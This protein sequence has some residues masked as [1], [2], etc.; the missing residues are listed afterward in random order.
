[1]E[2]VSYSETPVLNPASLKGKRVGMVMFSSY[3]ADPRPR[4]AVEALLKEGM[5]VDLVCLQDEHA[6]KRETHGCLDIIRVPVTHKR[7]GKLSYAYTYS[8]FIL[9]SAGILAARSL[10]RRYDL[11]YV[12]NMP[13]ILVASALVPKALG[14]KVILDQHDPM[15]ELMMTIFN[16]DKASRGVRLLTRLEKWSIARADLVITVNAVCKRIFGARSCPPEKIGV[17]MNS[18]DEVI[19][20][21]QAAQS[22]GLISRTPPKRFVMMYHGSLVE[23]NGLDLAVEAL[24]RVR[25]AIPNAELRIYGRKTPFLD[26]VMTK[27]RNNGLAECVAYLGP[28]SLEGL[29]R[30][31]ETCN[32][33]LIPNHRSAFAEINTPTRIFE[34]LALGKPVIA[35]RAAGISDYFADGS[36]I[37][38]EL[39]DAHDLA[40]KIEYAFSHPAEISET[41][42]RGQQVYREHC[43]QTER[44]RLTDLVGGLLLEGVNRADSTQQVRHAA[45]GAAS[46]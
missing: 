2:T 23:R 29:V 22:S 5:S 4:R 34:Y 30:E 6:P 38:F 15:P 39:G 44:Q 11:I 31:I 41:V 28:R 25:A 18:P 27:A 35:P 32:L 13:D 9:I 19:F 12:H 33:G 3:P 17:V 36:M 24:A 7:G 8:A 26:S 16:L 37:F 20:P 10:K 45:Q 21:F 1:M 42:R 46:R 40:E 14:A 43:W